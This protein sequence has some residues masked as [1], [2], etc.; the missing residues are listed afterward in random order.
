MIIFLFIFKNLFIFF[1]V[2]SS[3][4]VNG[5]K[6]WCSLPSQSLVWLSLCICLIMC[7][8]QRKVLLWSK[9]IVWIPFVNVELYNFWTFWKFIIRICGQ[10]ER[11]L[12]EGRIFFQTKHSPGIFFFLK[13]PPFIFFFHLPTKIWLHMWDSESYY[14]SYDDY[15]FVF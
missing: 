3:Y 11:L 7:R 10:V 8:N 2:L 4:L 14:F 13:Y 6:C 1:S 9:K 5:N 15:L 12:V